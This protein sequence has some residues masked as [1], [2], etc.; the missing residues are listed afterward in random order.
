MSFAQ[1]GT[2]LWMTGSAAESSDLAGVLHFCREVARAIIAQGIRIHAALATG[3]GAL[4]L[5]V[6]GRLSVASDVASRAAATVA[7][8]RSQ[9]PSNGAS[10]PASLLVDSGSVDLPRTVVEDAGWRLA[11]GKDGGTLYLLQR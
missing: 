10:P 4:F 11:P 7:V 8:L 1:A 9:L 5:D 2:L 3:S 6:E